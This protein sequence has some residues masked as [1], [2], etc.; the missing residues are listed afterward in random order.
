[1][2]EIPCSRSSNRA[3]TESLAIIQFTV[4][5]F[6][7]SRRNSTR[8]R[9]AS[10]ASLS[11]TSTDRPFCSKSRSVCALIP[12]T[13]AAIS[14]MAMTGR[15]TSFPLGSPMRPVPPPSRKMGRWPQRAAWAS[16]ITG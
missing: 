12:E 11:R 5:C 4:K 9:S 2:K 3:R 1:M 16:S 7:V 14:S 13:L 6:P 8:F 10:Q 15:S